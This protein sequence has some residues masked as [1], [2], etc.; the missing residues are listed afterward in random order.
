METEIQVQLPVQVPEW[1][2]TAKKRIIYDPNLPVRY[3]FDGSEG[4]YRS[5]SETF[6]S[7]II[8]PLLVRTVQNSIRYGR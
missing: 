3:Q 4:V 1:A 6:D 7:L 5:D 2:Q 8:Q